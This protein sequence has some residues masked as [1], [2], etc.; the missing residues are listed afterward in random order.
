M[1][2]VLTAVLGAIVA[3]SSTL[4][5]TSL[6]CDDCDEV[7]VDRVIDGD[8]FD[9]PSGR[10]RLF[11]IDTPERGERCATEA[12]NRLSQ[13]SGGSVRLEDGPRLTDRFGRRLAYVYTKDGFSI[14]EVLIREGLGTAW[15]EDAQHR[16]YLV[17]LERKTK[18]NK[19][20]CLWSK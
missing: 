4:G 18:R 11:G 16:D 5:E 12:A 10:V 19:A 8:T 7:R 3:C 14:D 2:L 15:T 1:R 6:R 9:T 20:G 13:L 17:G